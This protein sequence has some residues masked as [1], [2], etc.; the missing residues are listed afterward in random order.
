MK[1]YALAARGVLSA[2]YFPMRALPVDDCK[3]VFLSRQSDGLTLD[4]QMAIDGLR[5]DAPQA[6]IVTI[7][8]RTGSGV[9]AQAR[10]LAATLRSL[11]H[12]ATSKVVVLDAYWPAVS[13]VNLRR[14]VTVFQMWH[15]LGKIKQSGRANLDKE[16]GRDQDLARTMR[17]HEGYDFVVAGA[18][19]WNRFYRESFNVRDD[20]LLNIGLPRGDY[21]Y[22]QREQIRGRVLAK[23]P[24]LTERPVILYAPTFRRVGATDEG[25]EKLLETLDTDRYTVVVKAHPNQPLPESVQTL[26][27]AE[28]T[29]PELLTVADYL[30]TDYSAIAVEAAVIDVPTYYYLYDLEQYLATNGMN[31]DLEKETPGCTFRT[32]AEL[33]EAL[34]RPYPQQTLQNYKEK[35]VV[36]ELGVATK[37]LTQAIL[38]KGRLCTH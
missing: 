21:L 13:A 24:Q 32:A 5:E 22:N 33:A 7:C 3:V 37:N 1:L 23:Y 2:L 6:K 20:Q 36:S 12:L 16:A 11:Y 30:V 38:G 25:L 35:F 26:S 17:M 31:L 14:G 34:E 4:F 15:S 19:A 29:A 8:A 28:F 27:C 10:F 18:P 9:E